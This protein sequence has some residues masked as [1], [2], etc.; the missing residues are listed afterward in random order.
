MKQQLFRGLK[1][2]RTVLL[3]SSVVTL[4]WWLYECEGAGF[5]RI[6]RNLPYYVWNDET[7][8]PRKLEV[9]EAKT[10]RLLDN[11]QPE[12]YGLSSRIINVHMQRAGLYTAIGEFKKT[13]NEE[14][15]RDVYG[16]L[17]KTIGDEYFRDK[18]YILLDITDASDYALWIK[19]LFLLFVLQL[20]AVVTISVCL[21]RA[22]E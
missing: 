2:V 1:S 20:T 4:A 16:S 13:G 21:S 9:Y 15:L 14:A 6:Y 5:R 8:R 22:R 19:H 10:G 3:C 17:V 18:Q 7:Y 11:Q 12:V